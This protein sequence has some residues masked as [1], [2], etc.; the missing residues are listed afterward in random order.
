MTDR[1]KVAI[2]NVFFPPFSIGGATRVVA[3]NVETIQKHYS[4]E[5]E[6]VAFSTHPD[7]REEYQLDVYP[8]CGI[9]VY[10]LHTKL[11][12]NQEWSPENEVVQ[13]SFEDFLAIEK[14]DI[15]HFHCVQRLTASV[16][17]AALIKKIPYLVTVH[18]AWWISDYQFLVDQQGT[19]FSEGHE[20]TLNAPRPPVGISIA[21][22]LERRMKLKS[23]L[24]GAKKILAVSESFA[25]L[26]RRNGFPTCEVSKNGVSSGIDWQPK[27]TAAT[28]KVVL[29]HFGGMSQH[30]GYDLVKDCLKSIDAKNLQLVVVDHSKGPEFKRRARW[31]SCEVNFIGRQPQDAVLHLYQSI[32]VLLAPSVWPESFGLVTREALACGCWVVASDIGGIGEDVEEGINGHLVNAGSQRDLQRVLGL[33]TMNPT[34]Y[35][36]PSKTKSLRYSDEQAHELVKHHYTI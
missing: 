5:V 6:L 3:D 2:V 28:K 26:Y 30:K 17:K 20:D 18:D 21:E 9:R 31:G 33:I 22:S 4:K 13:K 36:G 29:G 32:D 7:H 24:L 27:D 12:E 15:I 10:T 14:P 19:V 34:Q 11:F 35:K 1:L 8:Y 25:D 23:L 16:L